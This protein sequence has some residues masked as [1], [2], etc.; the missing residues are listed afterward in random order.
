MRR[1]KLGWTGCDVRRGQ[2]ADL[3]GEG[4]GGEGGI[5]VVTVL[6]SQVEALGALSVRGKAL[7][8]FGPCAAVR[9]RAPATACGWSCSPVGLVGE[10]MQS[11]PGA[12]ERPALPWPLARSGGGSSSRRLLSAGQRILSPWG[13][14]CALTSGGGSRP[15]LPSP[16]SGHASRPREPGLPCRCLRRGRSRLGSRERGRESAGDV[17]C[18][19]HRV[20]AWVAQEVSDRAPSA[21]RLPRP[22]KSKSRCPSRPRPLRESRPRRD[23]R[24]RRWWG[25]GVACACLPCP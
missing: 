6:G 16:V 12:V 20:P 8:L 23:A 11:P 22:T 1:R 19:F 18:C 5:P 24:L 2:G 4:G 21:S 25:R 15:P 9:R 14:R 7:A 13:L 17:R 3:P 10:A